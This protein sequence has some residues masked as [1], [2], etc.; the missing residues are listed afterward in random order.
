MERIE[1]FIKLEED[2]GVSEPRWACLVED[3]SR[4]K[5]RMEFMEGSDRRMGRTEPT[6]AAYE[7]VLSIF[8]DPVYKI[9]TQIKDKPYFKRPSKMVSDLRRWNP[10]LWCS[11]HREND[12]MTENYRMLK[13]HLEDLVRKGH[14]KEYV[15]DGCAKKAPG[16]SKRKEVKNV[17]EEGAPI[18]VIDVVHGAVNPA[19]VTTQSVRTQR[20]MAA[21]LKE[22]Y[23]M[24]TE[25]SFV[26]RS[27]QVKGEISF[28]DEDLRDV[29]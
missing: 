2:L 13:Q 17:A 29:V 4:R 14:L 22:V 25:P 7:G 26:N 20:K 12:H 6:R 18:G 16:G 8:K 15:E 1:E 11:Y 19:E 24:S 10:N 3:G 23:Q 9:P 27:R 5:R 21:H 28:S